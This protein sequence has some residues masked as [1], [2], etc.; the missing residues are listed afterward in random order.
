MPS[1]I[2]GFK[3]GQIKWFDGGRLPEGWSHEDPAL[4]KDSI[5]DKPKAKTKAQKKAEAEAA[6][7]Q[8]QAELDAEEK[9]KAEAAELDGDGCPPCDDKKE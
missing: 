2:C 4:K 6:D 8:A 9:A 7:A 3:N 1:Q 5:P